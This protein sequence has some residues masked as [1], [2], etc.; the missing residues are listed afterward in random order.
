V[1]VEIPLHACAL[2]IENLLIDVDRRRL[3]VRELRIPMSTL[4]TEQRPS[5]A[6][7]QPEQLR[8]PR[9]SGIGAPRS[10]EA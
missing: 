5:S 2:A 7:V 4:S 10:R 8:Q 1:T 9:S 6:V 3:K